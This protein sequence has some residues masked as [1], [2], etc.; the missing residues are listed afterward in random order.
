MFC[1]RPASANE[2]IRSH[3]RIEGSINSQ[4]V[5]DEAVERLPNVTLERSTLTNR[6]SSSN[7]AA[8]VLLEA[9]EEQSSVLEHQV[10]GVV[11]HSRSCRYW[12]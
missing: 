6:V 10:E 7:A 12:T 9:G 8:S 3:L 11:I 5:G 4:S 2:V 1:C